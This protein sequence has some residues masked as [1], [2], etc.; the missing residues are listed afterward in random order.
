ME[1]TKKQYLYIPRS[2]QLLPGVCLREGGD[3]KSQK[4]RFGVGL[5]KR[6]LGLGCE[7]V[8]AAATVGVAV[9]M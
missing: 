5:P 4:W 9:R 1:F 6:Y 2:M 8:A 3:S 7:C